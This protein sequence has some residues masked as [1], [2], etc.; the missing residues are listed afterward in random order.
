MYKFHIF[1]Q[2]NLLYFK[3]S[4]YCIAIYSYFLC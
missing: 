4:T 1:E 3:L 2:I